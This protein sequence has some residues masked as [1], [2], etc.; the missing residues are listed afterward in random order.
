MISRQENALFFKGAFFMG[1]SLFLLSRPIPAASRAFI[2]H[3]K[4]QFY[5]FKKIGKD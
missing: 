2:R 4:K 3:G 5:D 1:A